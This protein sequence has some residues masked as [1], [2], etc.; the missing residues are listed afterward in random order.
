MIAK[1]IDFKRSIRVLFIESDKILS[2][3]ECFSPI[4]ADTHLNGVRIGLQLAGKPDVTD[5]IYEDS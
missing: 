1:I 2:T 3:K 5:V 4:E